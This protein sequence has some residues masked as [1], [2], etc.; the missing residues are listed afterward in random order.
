ML[1][2]EQTLWAALIAAAIAVLSYYLSKLMGTP[3]A[4]VPVPTPD[5]AP[6][7]VGV[8]Y[9]LKPVTTLQPSFKGARVGE[10]LDIAVPGGTDY[11][12][13]GPAPRSFPAY[14]EIQ[15]DRVAKAWGL[16][17]EGSTLKER[18]KRVQECIDWARECGIEPIKQAINLYPMDWDQFKDYGASFRQLVLTGN[19]YPP[20]VA[21]PTPNITPPVAWLQKVDA[22]IRSGEL[23]VGSWIYAWDEGEGDE[24]ATKLAKDR[25]EYIKRYAPNVK[26]K[27]T[28]RWSADFAP[29][30]DV[31]FPVFELWDSK[32]T[33]LYGSCMAQGS[34]TNGVQG[35]PTGTPM[36]VLDAPK[37]HAY[38][39]P[40][41]AYALGA[42][43]CLYYCLTESMPTALMA[44]G[45][46]FAGG[47]GDGTLLYKGFRSVRLLEF[48]RGLRAIETKG[49][50][51]ISL[52]KS[53]KDWAG[54]LK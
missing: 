21:G 12:V 39:Y 2:I 42:K 52:V 8:G 11:Y 14:A 20:C 4:P 37:G 48:R 31:F 19:I 32:S 35:T 33:G 15:F 6:T 46:Y 25:C 36:M 30:V 3:T 38:A 44:G 49:A 26:V 53:A 40:I 24:A 50:T 28:R 18:A 47:N 23:P 51:L 43:E 27:I 22:A 9:S 45:Q 17:D 41:V 29:Y 1:S 54:L 16:A 34:C 5:P 7:P 10:Y 13:E